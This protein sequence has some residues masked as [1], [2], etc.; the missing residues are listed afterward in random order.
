MIQ[1]VTI[2]GMGAL[3]ILL[4]DLL[5]TGL[6]TEN[7]LFLA[8]EE[9]VKRYAETDISCN[10]HPCDFRIS[11]Q[12]EG[13]AELLIFAVKYPDLEKAMALAAPCVGEN[14]IILSLLNGVTTEE[15]LG[16][17]F[18][19]GKVIETVSQGMDA[20]RTGTT[21][22]YH[23]QGTFFVGLPEE[24]YFDRSEKLAAVMELAERLSLPFV[25][26]SD[27]LHR[28]WC[29]FM[30]NVGIN[31][32]CMAFETD[33]G[34]AQKPG[35]IRDT[36]IAA[37]HEVRKVGACQGVLVTQKDLAHYLEILDGL[38]PTAIPSMR[39][40]AL[41]HRKSEVELFAGTVLQMA[42]RYGMQTPV[43]QMLYDKIR[44]M[45]TNW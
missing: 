26:E 18:G 1:K 31:Q 36:M 21:L 39:Q 29:K 5:T 33:Y 32:V 45:E 9:R 12:T 10:G 23:N 25:Q 27:I 20:V 3:G 13:E 11:S 14:T 41:A 44:A 4:G 16:M 28:M 19:H 43:N 34:G 40:D 8:D 35:E 7:V 37:M 17:E 38:E 6:G 24:D 22:T 15:I 30:L 42:N 2:V